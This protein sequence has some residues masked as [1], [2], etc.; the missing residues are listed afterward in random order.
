MPS[1]F[2]TGKKKKYASLSNVKW[3]KH[4][5]FST[6][7]IFNK[8]RLRYMYQYL[9]KLPQLYSI[10]L[11][12]GKK[13]HKLGEDFL[14][15]VVKRVPVAFKQFAQ[16]LKAIKKL[17]AL[18][19]GSFAFTK[20]WQRCEPTDFNHAWL[21]VKLDA[22]V[23]PIDETLTVIDF[24]TGKPY[25]DTIDQSELYVVAAFQLADAV[26]NK[27]E[28]DTFDSID[29]EFWYLDSG[30]VV[31]YHYNRADFKRLKKKWFAR[32]AEMLKTRQFPATRNLYD[33]KWCPF[34]NDKKLGNGETGPCDKWKLAK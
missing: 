9:L 6:W 13:I 21:R 25:S 14:D 3:P 28:P 31:T 22:I 33:C 10:H 27:A 18:A 20:T 17:G 34:R 8:C 16:E 7:N 11:E 15:D 19:E 32:Q 12:R 26:F 23:P 4:W 5:S 29:V 24:K 1:K 2:S 30:E